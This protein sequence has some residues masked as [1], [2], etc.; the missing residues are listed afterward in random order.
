MSDDERRELRFTHWLGL[1]TF[2]LVLGMM[3]AQR[4]DDLAGLLAWVR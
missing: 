2:G 3:A 4:W 1:L